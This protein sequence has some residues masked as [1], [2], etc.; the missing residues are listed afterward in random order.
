MTMSY[1]AAGPLLATRVS[2]LLVMLLLIRNNIIW[3][4]RGGWGG[5]ESLKSARSLRLVFMSLRNCLLTSEAQP[6]PPFAVFHSSSS[7]VPLEDVT[8]PPPPL[9]SCRHIHVSAQY[10]P[11]LRACREWRVRYELSKHCGRRPSIPRPPNSQLN[12][13]LMICKAGIVFKWSTL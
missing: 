1:E 11:E 7:R 13:A 4:V 3:S 8:H 12:L 2:F 5:K 6:H 10:V 9:P